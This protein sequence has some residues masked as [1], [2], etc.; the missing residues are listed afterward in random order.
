MIPVNREGAPDRGATVGHE[1]LGVGH[2]VQEGPLDIE[3]RALDHAR[4]RT[5]GQTEGE[6]EEHV[7]DPVNLLSEIKNIGFRNIFLAVPIFG[8]STTFEFTN[9]N[10][11]HRNLSPDHLYLYSKINIK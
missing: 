7:E 3:G 10:Y 6:E 1:G 5:R 8:F 9:D 4:E 11:Y 2:V